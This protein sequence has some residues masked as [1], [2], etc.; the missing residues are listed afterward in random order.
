MKWQNLK[1]N[2][3]PKCERDI[4][5]G[6]EVSDIIGTFDR[7]MRHSCGFQIRESKYRQIVNSQITAE[8]E[9]KWDAEEEGGEK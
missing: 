6:L 5:R 1:Q 9:K 8:L 3:C 4:W 2:K 7:M